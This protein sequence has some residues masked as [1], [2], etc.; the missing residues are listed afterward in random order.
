M[1]SN[2]WMLLLIP[3]ILGCGTAS[4]KVII[5]SDPS[6]AAVMVDDQEIG[7]TPIEH[8]FKFTQN[9]KYAKLRVEKSRYVP[10]VQTIV[11][12]TGTSSSTP[13]EIDIQLEPKVHEEPIIINSDPP[14]ADVTLNDEYLGST[15]CEIYINDKNPDERILVKISKRGYG[16]KLIRIKYRGE[17]WQ[18]DNFM[19]QIKVTLDPV[20][21]YE[22]AR[23][24]S[25]GST[26]QQQGSPQQMGPTIA[27]TIVVP[28]GP[29]Q[30]T[31]PTQQTKE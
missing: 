16:A 28:S 10:Y 11:K 27:P 19:D 5:K 4:R 23:T 31:G 26:G 25:G 15:P 12:Q 7:T 22:D 30:Q 21:T 6:D 8:T 14:N 17:T 3:I 24:M 1:K 13:E 20:L 29:V 9:K 2:M 18:E